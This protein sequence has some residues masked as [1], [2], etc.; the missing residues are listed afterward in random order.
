M[1]CEHNNAATRASGTHSED[2][3]ASSPASHTPLPAT[4]APRLSSLQPR[5][6]CCTQFAHGPTT[7]LRACRR[8][9]DPPTHL[10]ATRPPSSCGT[11]PRVPAGTGTTGRAAR[12]ATHAGRHRERLTVSER[13]SDRARKALLHEPCTSPSSASWLRRCRENGVRRC[14]PRPSGGQFSDPRHFVRAVQIDAGT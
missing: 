1:L 10:S 8:A 2:P 12:A 14:A 7:Q 5:A 9:H 4:G 6:Q 11:S 13:H 3:R